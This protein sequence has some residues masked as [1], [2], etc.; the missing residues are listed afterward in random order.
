MRSSSA[1][2]RASP[3]DLTRSRNSLDCPNPPW[4]P[5]ASSRP[6]VFSCSIR[7]LVKKQLGLGLGFEFEFGALSSVN[8]MEFIPTKKLKREEGTRG[9]GPV[10]V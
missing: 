10:V 3:M 7:V 6:M 5:I 4:E 9:F 8:W 1:L 2:D